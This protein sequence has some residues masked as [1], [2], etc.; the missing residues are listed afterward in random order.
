MF[1]AVEG[2]LDLLM[3]QSSPQ[4]CH[5]KPWVRIPEAANKVW[6]LENW[7]H[8]RRLFPDSSIPAVAGATDLAFRP[9]FLTFGPGNW[10]R[11]LTVRLTCTWSPCQKPCLLIPKTVPVF[12]QSRCDKEASSSLTPCASSTVL[13]RWLPYTLCLGLGSFVE[14]A[15]LFYSLDL[16]V[17][18]WPNHKLK[19]F[20]RFHLKAQT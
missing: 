4:E 15:L 12:P 2:S 8:R 16:K 5:L 17:P 6:S 3:A 20:T 10:C 9:S 13:G 7:G 14:S 11:F 19:A 1:L 18:L